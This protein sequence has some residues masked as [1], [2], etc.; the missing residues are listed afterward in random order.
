MK[1][2]GYICSKKNSEIVEQIIQNHIKRRMVKT[3]K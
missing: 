3:I 2:K 1:R